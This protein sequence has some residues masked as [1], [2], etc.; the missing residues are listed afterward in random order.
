MTDDERALRRAII[1]TCNAMTARGLNQ[2]TSGNVS[3]RIDGGLLITPS[4]L[5]YE[6]MT[7]E[8]IVELRFDGSYRGAHRPSSEWRFHRDILGARPDVDVVLHNH[9]TFATTLSCFERGIPP[10]HYM[11]AV[12][13][14]HDI[15]VSPYACFG[16]QELSDRVLAALEGR[17][18][19]LMGHHG[20]V[21]VAPTLEKALKLAVEVETL[22]KMYVHALAIGEPP[23]LSAAEMDRVL[24]QMRRMS[25]GHAPDLDD[26]ADTPDSAVR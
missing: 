3:R 18:A 24:A 13:G 26:V 2:G 20:L 25:Y 10:F 16:T 9:A 14:G 7:P 17:F 19:C 4:G 15:R 21:T 6:T 11:T 1:D 22:S 23:H 8:D 5:A 12:A